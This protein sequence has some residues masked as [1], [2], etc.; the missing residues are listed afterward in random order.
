MKK[1]YYI[2]AVIVTTALIVIAVSLSLCLLPNGEFQ[3]PELILQDDFSVTCKEIEGADGYYYIVSRTGREYDQG[4]LTKTGRMTI[5]PFEEGGSYAVKAQALYGEK[6]SAFSEEIY[7]TVYDVQ[8]PQSDLFTVVGRP[9]YYQNQDYSFSVQVNEGASGTP[10]VLVNG[11]VINSADE[12]YVLTAPGENLVISVEGITS[13]AYAA[14]T[15]PAQQ[16][17]YTIHAQAH[18][19]IGERYTFTVELDPD[20]SE[21]KIGVRINGELLKPTSPGC[22]TVDG[23]SGDFSISVEGVRENERI[24][25]DT[26]PPQDQGGQ[27]QPPATQPPA[28]QPPATQPPATQPPAVNPEIP[29]NERLIIDS[30]SASITADPVLGTLNYDGSVHDTELFFSASENR[31]CAVNWEMSGTITKANKANSLFLSFGVR[32]EAGKDKWFCLLDDSMALQRYWNWWDTKQT[33]DGVNLRFNQAGSDFFY[34]RN[35]V[36]HYRIVLA[37]DVLQVYFGN[38]SRALSL[39][40]NLPLTNSLYGGFTAGSAYQ[41]GINTVDPAVMTISNVRVTASGFV[42]LSLDDL[43]VRD[44]YILQANGSYYL[45]GTKY[46]GKF[47]V[48]TSDN[49]QTWYY[50]GV[51]FAGASDFWGNDTS[52]SEQAYWAPEVHAYNGA[53]YMFATFTRAGTQNQ[54]ATA[55]LKSDSPV[56][57][58]VQWSNGPITPSGHSCLDGTLY[59]ENGVPYLIYAHEW[60]CTCKGDGIGSMGYIQL[61]ADLKTTVGSPAEWFDADEYTNYSYL[62]QLFGKENTGVT[63]GP[64]VYEANGQKYLLWS[65]TLDGTYIQVATKFSYIGENINVK[66]SSSKLYT[67]DGGHGMIFTGAD[68]NAYLVLHTPNSGD[69]RAVVYYVINTDGTLTLRQ[70]A[71]KVWKM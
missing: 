50:G 69:T 13:E 53:Y 54:Q 55:I 46:F 21:S 51:C 68:D 42:G 7:I 37:D 67:A 62:E 57:P 8:L 60:Q 38:D 14:V 58:F 36:L 41:I 70:K 19:K 33:N 5:G 52:N 18:A 44:P 39:A 20:Y 15:L 49:L 3:V 11:E 26:L 61:S 66:N 2:A 12:N 25:E 71:T 30:A 31:A 6:R 22:Y 65:T 9:C 29:V 24:P 27:T 23:V 28:T 17:G 63:D 34:N 4:V 1:K 56:G 16:V 47:V 32:D 48:Y 45:Y 35:A 64:F 59:I 40:W 10:V 43:F